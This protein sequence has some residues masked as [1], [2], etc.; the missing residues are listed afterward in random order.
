MVIHG[1]EMLFFVFSSSAAP[2]QVIL[3]CVES[4]SFIQN[5]RSDL[6]NLKRK[7]FHFLK[8]YD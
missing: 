2:P 3:T 1:A 5:Q 4:S 8:K 6:M 7:R